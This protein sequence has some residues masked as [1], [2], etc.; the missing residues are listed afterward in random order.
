MAARERG[1]L[2]VRTSSG[3]LMSKSAKRNPK[4][5]TLIK[6]RSTTEIGGACSRESPALNTVYLQIDSAVAGDVDMPDPIVIFIREVPAFVLYNDREQRERLAPVDHMEDFSSAQI[7]ESIDS[8][9]QRKRMVEFA[10]IEKDH[11]AIA[12]SVSIICE[13]SPPKAR[14]IIG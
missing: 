11:E 6:K 13:P 8:H 2:G 14:S 7:P 4:R 5:G 3:E 10:D 12:L 1:W 9:F